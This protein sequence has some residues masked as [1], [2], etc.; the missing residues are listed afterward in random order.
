MPGSPLIMNGLETALKAVV[1]ATVL[2]W[3]INVSREI[4]QTTCRAIYDN[5]A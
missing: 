1:L 2:Y 5:A 3:M 4:K